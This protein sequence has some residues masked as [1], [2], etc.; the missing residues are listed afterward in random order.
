MTDADRDGFPNV[1][2]ARRTG[3]KHLLDGADVTDPAGTGPALA[4]NLEAVDGVEVDSRIAGVEHGRFD[5]GVGRVASRSGGDDFEGSFRL[6]WRGDALDG[7][8]TEDPVDTYQGAVPL[9][10]ELNDVDVYLTAGGPILR[11]R[12]WYFAA[13]HRTEQESR[14]VV[15]GTTIE[16]S[17]DGWSN[18]AKISWRPAAGHALDLRYASGPREFDG[19]FAGFG[20]SPESDGRWIQHGRTLQSRWIWAPSGDLSLEAQASWLDS[21]IAV[22]PVSPLFHRNRIQT[23]VDAS[24]SFPAIQAVYPTRECSTDGTAAGFVPDCDPSLGRVSLSHVDLGTGLVS[25]PLWFSSDDGRTR[26]AVRT[27]AA[28]RPRA[29]GGGHDVRLGFEADR[30]KLEDDAV[31]NP[32]LYDAT[33]PCPGCRD[34]QGRPIPNAVIGVQTLLVPRPAEPFISVEGTASSFWL[35]D[36]W[37][38]GRGVVVQAGVRLDRESVGAAGFTSFDPVRDR[39]RS[40]TL[41]NEF[42][43]EGLRIEQAGG[44]SNASSAC[45]PGAGFVP[46]T[47]PRFGRLVFQMDAN[48]PASIRKHDRVVDGY[49]DSLGDGAV[50]FDALT[51][52]RERLPE[53][54]RVTNVNLSPR[55]GASWDPW[56]ADPARAG[57][58]RLF[59]AWGRYHD[60][61]TLAVPASEQTPALLGFTFAPDPASSQFQPGQV[62]FPAGPPG[63]MQVDRGL[64]TPRTDVLTLGVVR[65]VS[66]RWS[67]GITYTQRLSRD[68]L[69]DEDVNHLPCR[70][71]RRTFGIDPTQLCPAFDP[72]GN[73]VAGKDLFGSVSAPV[74]NGLTDLFVVNPHFNQVLR[75]GDLDDG[76]Y[77]GLTLEV[78]RALFARWQLQGSYTYG[79]AIGDAEGFTGPPRDDP[80][81]RGAEGAH[82]AWDQRHR[83][84]MAAAG[85]VPGDVEFGASLVWDSG[86]PY[87]VATQVLDQDNAGNVNLR[88]IYPT[89]SRN[90]QRNGGTWLLEAR[91]AKRFPAGKVQIAAE[92]AVRNLL[93][94]DGV[95]LEAFDPSASGGAQLTGG[96]E[97][98]RR[99]GRAWQLGLA[100]YF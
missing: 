100:A 4:L 82:L 92:A 72:N 91:A 68:L 75:V 36:A 55:L 27:D 71:L 39:I 46:W 1:L 63:V 53:P 13:I 84:V 58:T 43:A 22:R 77:R 73:V 59:A 83:V 32:I 97:G 76:R 64:R 24:G 89:G 66:P 96:P 6:L 78:R 50:W 42:C 8:G 62:S 86:T 61:I 40:I 12:L 87:T 2:G 16:Q 14:L 60:R 49:F 54:F 93:D 45:G 81:L 5:G 80:A 65:E 47:G 35:S 7:D 67:V 98:L 90:D 29:G 69:Q 3:L 85:D 30:E 70:R 20:V 19:V 34:A 18:L 17:V 23:R 28:L 25:G 37:R 21:G 44:T 9:A 15:P 41:V 88:Q 48:T 79:R 56:G 33:I 38:A 94:E 52:F 51:S 95:V 99:S 57:R 10:R 31:H 11:G 74:P 26:A